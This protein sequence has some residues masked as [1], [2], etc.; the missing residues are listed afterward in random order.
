[1]TLLLCAS[2]I[3]PGCAFIKADSCAD[4][5]NLSDFEKFERGCNGGFLSAQNLRETVYNGDESARLWSG[6]D[7]RQAPNI[8][9]GNVNQAPPTQSITGWSGSLRVD[10]PDDA[11]IVS[12]DI[13][14][15][16]AAG[17]SKFDPDEK[18]TVKFDKAPLDFFLK[19]MLSGALGVAYVASDDLTG[20]VTFR[21]EQPISK[22]QVLQVVRDVLARNGLEM[23]YMSGVY[24]IAAPDVMATLQQTAAPGRVSDRTTRVIRLHKGS[25]AEV[26]AFLRQLMPD[27]VSLVA[28]TSGDSIIV[29][30][31]PEE[32][33]KVTELINIS[34]TNVSDDRVAIIPLRQSAPEKI[35]QQLGEFYR[36]QAEAATIIPLENQ[37]ALLVGT[38][39]RRTMQGLKEL[40]RRLDRDTGGDST[41]RII[42]L[43][44]LGADEVVPLL[45]AIYAN[46][47]QG[48]IV[49]SAPA[50]SNNNNGGN[51]GTQAPPPAK[52]PSM[53]PPVQVPRGTANGDG[54]FSPG[55]SPGGGSGSSG[56]NDAGNGGSTNVPAQ[57]TIQGGGGAAPAVRF[58]ADTRNNTVMIYSSYAI[59]RSVRERL[60]ILD[61]PQA[62]VVIEATVA[63]VTLSDE[64]SHGVEAFL[65]AQ[66]L[67]ASSSASG[68]IPDFGAR[69]AGGFLHAQFGVP[70]AKADVILQAL[71]SVTN[72]KIIS[73]PYLTVVDGK[74]AK[75]VIGD[76]IP[77][78]TVTQTAQLTG[79]T[80]VTQQITVKDTGIVLEVA[81]KIKADNSVVLDINQSV[82]DAKDNKTVG[83]LTPTIATRS[84][85]SDVIVQS[86][87]TIMLAGLVK[88]GSD[89]TESGIPIA[90]SLPIVGDLFKQRLDKATRQ[91]LIVLIT[92]RVIR[93]STQ[94]ENITRQMRGMM[95]VRR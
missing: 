17:A 9:P 70:G 24:Q 14:D 95:H 25:A 33:D 6:E 40:V 73:T 12:K 68:A 53:L 90:R 87:A 38:R 27:E 48:S 4:Q 35:T 61:V 93:H 3:L 51:G 81:P 10:V 7:R 64:L 26:I 52:N 88:E 34:D 74:K 30:A 56:D 55:F 2:L 15:I 8:N 22:S 20:S 82:S 23:R 76:Q 41:L 85:Q 84:V 75:L 28:S 89:L 36:S 50:Q 54:S 69:P 32:I 77:F 91:E 67:E 83:G 19:Q 42:P 72:V 59:F 94:L 37:Q 79:T 1:L 13:A 31:S 46:T 57:P 60:K 86:G 47:G 44:H 66:G 18:V 39:D 45:T 21:T 43:T 16:R 80:T 29:K 11:N 92:P 65:T 5:A 49:T 71:Q 78:S 63:E 58:V 62:Q